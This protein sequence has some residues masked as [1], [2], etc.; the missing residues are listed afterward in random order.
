MTIITIIFI[1][2]HNKHHDDIVATTPNLQNSIN[3]LSDRISILES[4]NNNNPTT[5]ITNDNVNGNGNGCASPTC[6]DME[7]S[8]PSAFF[9]HSLLDEM[10]ITSVLVPPLS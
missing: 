6:L 10:P 7:S 4:L 2:S 1:D 3:A 5:A 9:K 8:I